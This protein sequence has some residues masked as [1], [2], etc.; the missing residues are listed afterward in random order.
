MQYFEFKLW[1]LKNYLFF[2]IDN[3]QQESDFED[4]FL[5]TLYIYKFIDNGKNNWTPG[6]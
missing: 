5:F 2:C 4:Y 3:G 1:A 6:R